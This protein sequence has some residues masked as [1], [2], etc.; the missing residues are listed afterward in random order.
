MRLTLPSTDA[1][2]GEGLHDSNLLGGLI[3]GSSSNSLFFVSLVGLILSSNFN[4][5]RISVDDCNC[6]ETI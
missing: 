4:L 3:I 1:D 6:L 2:T 5:F